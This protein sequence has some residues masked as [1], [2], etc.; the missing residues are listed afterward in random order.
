M[1]LKRK[2]LEANE[3]SPMPG[4]TRPVRIQYIKLASHKACL[5]RWQSRWMDAGTGKQYHEYAPQVGTGVV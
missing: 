1:N 4:E 2:K 3:E 5:A